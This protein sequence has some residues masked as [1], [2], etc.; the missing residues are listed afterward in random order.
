MPE[1]PADK[2]ML[3]QSQ[4]RMPLNGLKVLDLTLAR[5]GPTCVRHLADWGADVIKI[6][7]PESGDPQRGLAA[8]GLVP[9]GPG[10]VAH[11]MELPNRGKRSYQLNLSRRATTSPITMVAG[12]FI[13]ASERRCGRFSRVPTIVS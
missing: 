5:A 1:S 12:G 6:E 13:P 9:T 11:M 4:T 3:T 8:S 10:G 7:H 2:S